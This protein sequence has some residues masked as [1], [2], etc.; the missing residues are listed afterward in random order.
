[1]SVIAKHRYVVAQAWC[2]HKS[3]FADQNDGVGA[4]FGDG[5][6]AVGAMVVAAVLIFFMCASVCVCLNI[7]RVSLRFGSMMV[8]WFQLG[9]DRFELDISVC[10][11]DWIQPPGNELFSLL[12]SNCLPII[13]VKVTCKKWPAH[14]LYLK[15]FV[16]ILTLT[17]ILLYFMTIYQSVPVY[18]FPL[19]NEERCEQCRGRGKRDAPGE[20]RQGTREVET[21]GVSSFRWGPPVNG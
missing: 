7:R 3:V 8:W 4:R 13:S 6:V 11:S 9:L 18:G 17:H 2:W 5:M 10:I 16:N 12:L 20:A 14:T 21:R 19:Y 1:M 15:Y